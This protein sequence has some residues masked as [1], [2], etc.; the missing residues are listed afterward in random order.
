MSEKSIARRERSLR[1]RRLRRNEKAVSPVVATLI[2]ILIAVAAAAALY[3]WLTGWQGGVTKSIG[4]P[5]IPDVDKF[6]IGGS[7]TVYPLSQDAIKWFQQNYSTYNVTDQQGGSVAGAEAYCAGQVDVGAASSSFTTAQLSGDGCSAALASAT[8][9]NV[10]AVDAIVGIVSA[11]NPAFSAVLPT[12]AGHVADGNFSLNSTTMLAIYV[13]DSSTV[14][15]QNS[16]GGLQMLTNLSALAPY[17]CGQPAAS[18]TGAVLPSTYTYLKVCPVPGAGSSFEWANIPFPAGC[19]VLAGGFWNTATCTGATSDVS[20]ITAYDRA[21]SSGT[22][23][24]FTQKYLLGAGYLAKDASGNSCGTDNQ[25][26]SCNI[27]V[28][29]ETGNP[30]LA[31]AVAADNTGLGFNSYGQAVAQVGPSLL[32]A[33]YQTNLK[34]GAVIQPTV[35]SVLVD[36]YRGVN[37]AAAYGPWRPLEYLTDGVPVPG[38]VIANYIQFVDGP[39]VNLALAQATGYISLYAA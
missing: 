29:H 36:G 21:D 34:G 28:T 31:A 4:Q 9:Q 16:P 38:T 19:A 17:L 11:N 39:G 37:L 24:G 12:P 35:T 3:L 14:P 15:T 6:S 1:Y 10:V 27:H 26:E 30:A 18:F 7:T 20:K 22:E 8:V 13:A 2:L 32:L 5:T 25:L 33:G 23:Q